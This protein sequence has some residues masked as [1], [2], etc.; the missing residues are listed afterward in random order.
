MD[1]CCIVLYIPRADIR[2]AWLSVREIADGTT[3]QP[4]RSP[5]LGA[6]ITHG[7][8][9]REAGAQ[10]YPTTAENAHVSWEK[11]ATLCVSLYASQYPVIAV[12]KSR[13][14]QP[15]VGAVKSS[16]VRGRRETGHRTGELSWVEACD[17]PLR[18]VGF[19]KHVP[20]QS[21]HYC[22]PSR[23]H[24]NI[25]N[26]V[27]KIRGSYKHIFYEWIPFTLRRETLSWNNLKQ[28]SAIVLGTGTF[29][30]Y[31]WHCS[32]EMDYFRKLQ[33]ICTIPYCVL[34]YLYFEFSWTTIAWAK[35]TY[36]I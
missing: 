26:D 32:Y 8:F 18:M 29:I 7:R 20:R 31:C 15:T 33:Y 2:N 14:G 27:T 21:S 6:R 9:E 11:T 36:R 22:I 24:N 5:Q 28:S 12:R 3:T 35:P 19:E 23:W 34:S 4:L 13:H 1:D 17:E 25:A 30:T 10:E 16:S